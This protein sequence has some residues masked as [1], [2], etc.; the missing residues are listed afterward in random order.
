MPEVRFYHLTK[1]P[2]ER[3]L[4]TMLQRTLE[5][6]QRAVV[7]GGHADRLRFLDAQLWTADDASFLPHGIDGDPDPDRHPVWL[8]TYPET[9]NSASVLFLV[10]GAAAHT[11]EMHGMETTAILFDGHDPAAVEAARVQWRTITGAGLAAVYWAQGDG[12]RWEKRH[13]SK[14]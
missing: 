10:D 3:A 4:P 6:G 12:G 8:T 5:R 7:R 2:L 13:E 1:I 14:G 11:D 9:P